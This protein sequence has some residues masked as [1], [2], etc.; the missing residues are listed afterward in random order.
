LTSRKE[1]L[2]HWHEFGKGC[3]GR[4]RERERVDEV[5]PFI[6]IR[7]CWFTGSVKHIGAPRRG[8]CLGAAPLSQ[9][10]IE[11]IWSGWAQG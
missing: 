3:G 7:N 2:Y 4:E 9:S 8:C 5:L 11:K 6:L 10:E 1:C